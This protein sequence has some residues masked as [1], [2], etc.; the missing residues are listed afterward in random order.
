VWFMGTALGNLI[1]ARIAG[2]FDANNLAAMPGQLMRIFWFGTIS[3]GVLLVVGLAVNRWI[4]A[5]E[6]EQAHAS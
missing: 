2:D 5:S 4:K 1:A 6:K 3:A